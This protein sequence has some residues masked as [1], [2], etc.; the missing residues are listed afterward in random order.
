MLD[1][2]P[3][4]IVRTQS[5]T[6]LVQREVERLILTGELAPG[7]R[8]NEQ[9]LAARLRVSR[10]PVREAL[11]GL[12]KAR[13][14]EAK[15]NR[16]VYV[17]ELSVEQAL[18][19]SEMRGL[20]TGYACARLAASS[21]AEQRARLAQLIETMAAAIAAGDAPA[22][23]EHNLAF[24]DALMDYAGNARAKEMY[25]ALVKESHLSRRK[26]LFS[27]RAMAESNAE[28]RV[29]LDAIRKGDAAAAREAGERH[30]VGGRRR[31]LD[32]IGM[33]EMR[34]G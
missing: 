7:E 31:F 4:D 20:L 1:T 12:E 23:Y 24:H 34:P 9:H 19:I 22:Y 21:T 30:I 18:E 5:L 15:V 27:A 16:G 17:R 13:L 6:S 26:S 29:I 25:D 10:G 3:I 11:R 28:H 14:V 33:A 32:A 8:I 2:P